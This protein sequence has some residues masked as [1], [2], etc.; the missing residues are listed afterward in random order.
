MSGDSGP[1]WAQKTPKE[2]FNLTHKIH[3]PNF[4]QMFFIR[5]Y[6]LNYDSILEF[7]GVRAW[8]DVPKI[9]KRGVNLPH[10]PYA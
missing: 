8:S 2:G 7:P 4:S 1:I 5:K 6:I 3:E 9:L 10:K